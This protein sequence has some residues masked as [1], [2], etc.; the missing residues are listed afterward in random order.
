VATVV[1]WLAAAAF[2]CGQAAY[3]WEADD[4]DELPAAPETMVL[5]QADL[6]AR[7]PAAFE[8]I[9]ARLLALRKDTGFQ[10][11]LAI[12]SG[13]TT[14]EPAAWAE[15]LHEAWIPGRDGV[16][17]VFE[18]DSR[19]VALSRP[20]LTHPE[21]PAR[22]GSLDYFAVIGRVLDDLDRQ[23]PEPAQV[24]QLAGLL[25]DGF[26]ARLTAAERPVPRGR[27]LKLGLLMVGGGALLALGAVVVA[28][29][30]RRPRQP[31]DRFWF[32]DRD[33]PERLGAPSGGGSVA[34]VKF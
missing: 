1:A 18:T 23:Q 9:S 31:G 27:S 11:Y 3:V 22:L 10:I 20:F 16:V 26:R 7:H 21:A 14:R 5:D 8:R 29:L 15:R 33:Q 24:D 34:T 13:L 28:R 6:L 4:R 12:Q 25:A 30:N 2:G 19:K 32:E 17:A